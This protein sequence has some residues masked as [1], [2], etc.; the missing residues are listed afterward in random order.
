MAPLF[1]AHKTSFTKKPKGMQRLATEPQWLSLHK[2]DKRLTLVPT[3]H[4]KVT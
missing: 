4:A 3:D 1:S 2:I